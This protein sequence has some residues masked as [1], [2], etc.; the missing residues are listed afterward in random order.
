[1]EDHPL[2]SLSPLV[3]F[4][5]KVLRNQHATIWMPAEIFVSPAKGLAVPVIQLV[6]IIV[7]AQIPE[8]EVDNI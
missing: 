8:H 7:I 4:E 3:F 6:L 5:I 1:M 2:I